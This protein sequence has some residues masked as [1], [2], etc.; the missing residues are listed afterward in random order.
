MTLD[1]I[2]AGQ[3]ATEYTRKPRSLRPGPA[4]MM[5]AASGSAEAYA[6]VES[7][8]FN[9]PITTMPP[10]EFDAHSMRCH[11]VFIGLDVERQAL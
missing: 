5:A 7:W 8:R 10:A 3:I 2:A 1:A 6:I 9:F 4:L 11:T